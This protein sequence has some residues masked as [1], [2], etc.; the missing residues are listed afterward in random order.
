MSEEIRPAWW[1]PWNWSWTVWGLL[2]VLM[3]ALL[4]FV[5]RAVFLSTV[6][7]MAEPFD[8]AAFVG[9]E[10]PPDEN[11]FTDYR[12]AVQMRQR[13]M[14][15]YQQRSA[16]EPI[17]H[18][19]VY[20]GGWDASVLVGV[21]LWGLHMGLTQGLLAALVVDTAPAHLRGTAFG[22]FNLASGVTML[23]ASTLA[24]A[25]WSAYGYQATFLSGG[26]FAGLALVGLV[27]TIRRQRDRYSPR[28]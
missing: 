27:V 7:A 21:A 19:E 1:K 10:I 2:V 14:Q 20:K 28:G 4:P 13:L 26:L 11:A 23:A 9:D 6:P 18:D 17:N 5:V 24:W 16:V 25:L 22:L 3:L 8:V 15:T 12:Q